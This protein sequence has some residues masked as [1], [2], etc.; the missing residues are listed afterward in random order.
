MPTDFLIVRHGQTD[1]NLAR[2]I[3]GATDIPLNETGLQQAAATREA[4]RGAEFDAV[5]SSHLQR[6]EVTAATINEPHSKA[7]HVDE[8]LAERTF[9]SVEGWTVEQI[10]AA[11]GSFDAIA[12]VE[13]WHAVGERMLAALSDLAAA[14]PNGRVLVVAHG[15]SIRAVLGAVQGIPPRE[16]NSMLNCSLTELRHHESGRWEIL[17]LNDNQ[18][19]PADL[20]T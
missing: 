8:R 9:G 16:V 12:D 1:W 7:H 17:S 10:N 11:Y 3:Q 6:A 19:L 2:R 14:Y 13:S 5:A 4:L 20:R 15:S 18:H